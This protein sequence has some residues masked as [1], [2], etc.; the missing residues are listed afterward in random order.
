MLAGMGVSRRSLHRIVWPKQQRRLLPCAQRQLKPRLAAAGNPG[1][2]SRC[3]GWSGVLNLVGH[4]PAAT[5]ATLRSLTHSVP[6]MAVQAGARTQTGAA[7]G[8]ASSGS[9]VERGGKPMGQVR[10]V[11][12][13]PTSAGTHQ[14]LL[15]YGS[16]LS[17][18]LAVQ[19]A[20]PRRRLRQQVVLAALQRHVDAGDLA[21]GVL[22]KV[23][24]HGRTSGTLVATFMPKADASCPMQLNVMVPWMHAFDHD[25]PCQLQFSGLYQV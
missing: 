10:C 2:Q 20:Q 8:E 6:T 11:V 12:C 1:Q 16:S 23:R 19:A 7:A 22:E 5:A 4:I 3:A 21:P 25:V 14:V 18:S 24:R 15:F 9:D 17:S 13:W